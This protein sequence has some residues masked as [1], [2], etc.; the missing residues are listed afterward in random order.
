L[1][2]IDITQE[3]F[4]SRVFPGDRAPGFERV[5]T[6]QADG[7]S[8]T[9]IA[10]CVHNGTH[11][12]AP[13]HFFDGGTPVDEIA[14]SVF[15]GRCSVVEMSGSVGAA[16]MAPVIERCE[17][18]LLIKGDAEI[19]ASAAEA[20]AASRILMLGVEGQS[21]DPPGAPMAAHRILLDKDVVL[22]EGLDLRDAAP[23][24]Y[25]LCAF[26]MKLA[27][28]EGAPVRAVLLAEA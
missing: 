16:E 24:A 5:R 14:L 8:L 18:R 12:D 27:G 19:T 23:G 15:Y 21:V 28:C 2:I 4:A 22:L 3:L 6:V 25:T 9:D 11:I 1:K 17:E 10:L 26:P 7:Y 20:I 13:M